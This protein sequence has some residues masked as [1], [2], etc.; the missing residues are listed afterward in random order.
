MNHKAMFWPLLITLWI[1]TPSGSES[2]RSPDSELLREGSGSIAEPNFSVELEI[3]SDQF[4]A[5]RIQ[6]IASDSSGIIRPWRPSLNC[7]HYIL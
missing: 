6:R 2:R 7:D 4:A 5:F 1:A 3:S